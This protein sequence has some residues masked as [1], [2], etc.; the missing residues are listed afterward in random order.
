MA[1]YTTSLNIDVEGNVPSAEQL[2]AYLSASLPEY[3]VPGVFTRLESLPLTPNGKLDRKALPAPEM[4]L[5]AT[6]R[7]PRTPQ[8]EILCALFAEVLGL[9]KVGLDDHFF[10][11]GG[12][13]LM[14]TRLV[15]RIRTTLGVEL[16]I[17]TLFECPTVGELGPRLRDIVEEGRSALVAGR[18]PEK[19]PLS[20]AQQRLWFINR[21][22]GTSVEYNMPWALHLKGELDGTAL[23]QALNAIAERHESLRT[24]FVEVEG[25]P[26]QVIEPECQIKLAVEDMSSEEG[27][28]QQER[29]Q[30]ELRSEARMP[31]D[32]IRGPVLRVK[33]LRLGVQ[34]HVLLRTMH[35]IVS[36][37]WSEGVF[38][39][40]LMV[41]YEAFREG[42]ENPLRP[43]RVQYADFALW[44]RKWLEGGALDRGLSYWK[45]QLA[46]IPARLELPADRPRPALQTFAG[47]A[48]IMTLSA[49][50][51]TALKRL[52]QN[53]QSTLYMTLLAAFGMLLS[54]YSGQDD[55]VVGSPIANRQ[56]EQ[57]EELIG[58]F[59]NSLVMRVRVQREMSFGELLGQVR[60]TA[61]AVY[62]HQDVPF[63]RLVEEL[64]PERSLNTTPLFQVMFAVQNA[65][66]DKQQLKQLEVNP[67]NGG[68]LRVR[69]DLEVHAFERG[70][71]MT[72]SWLYNRDLFDRWRMEQMSRHYVRMLDGVVREPGCA[73][74]RVEMLSA[75]ERHQLLY[76]WNETATAFPAD[77][78]VHQLFEEQVARTP[79]AIAVV[80]EDEEL[81]YAELNAKA[82]R[83]AHHL[84]DLGVKPDDRVAICLERGFEMIVAMLGVLKAGG[85]YLPLDSDY[86]IE[87]LR[88]MLQ[89]AQPIALLTH[90][91]VR[92]L[93]SGIG[94]K[95]PV[96]VLKDAAELELYP[97]SNLD[98][99]TIGVTPNHLAYVIYTSGS[100]G[101]PKGVMVEHGGIVRL[102]RNTNYVQL[103][104]DDVIAQASNASFDAATSD[105]GSLAGGCA[106]SERQKG[107]VAVACGTCQRHSEEQNN[108]TLFNHGTF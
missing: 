96:V 6:W 83:L 92:E 15:S 53:H 40:E 73:V 86:P 79:D 61:L 2:R 62:E 60:Q 24:R 7:A 45:E 105:M 35:H 102:V 76:D 66:M 33:L 28:G 95:L 23:E 46:G 89:D 10:D 21:L 88:L 56:E 17:R 74:G 4:A 12:H 72:V 13:S 27:S 108:D 103:C 71:E 80:S 30:E 48:C 47:E 70:G 106:L 94:G 16:A 14:A 99:S 77:K 43:L 64:S 26:F 85:A 3:M 20:H 49:A 91:K 67:V 58:F 87:R 84:R 29:V 82:N 32:L 68:E 59:V 42:R 41:L 51:V 1:Y 31:F 8:E 97:E 104:P 78:C 44:Q 19:L 22:E 18:R 50:Q 36:D 93:L 54:R 90:T 9:E 63:E 101:V 69:F 57:L 37:G 52:S 39:R 5:T 38:T 98:C 81:T 75:K 11:L 34:D 100:T 65:R 55:I 107:Y 25:E